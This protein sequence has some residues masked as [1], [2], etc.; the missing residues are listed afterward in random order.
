MRVRITPR[1]L[2][3]LAAQFAPLPSEPQVFWIMLVGPDLEEDV[4]A[5]LMEAIEAAVWDELAPLAM[6]GEI[7][8][9]I[10]VFDREH[11]RVEAVGRWWDLRLDIKSAHPA[12][13]IV[14][15]GM[16]PWLRRMLGEVEGDDAG[17]NVR[18]LVE[19]PCEEKT[20]RSSWRRRR[21][22]AWLD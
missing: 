5:A 6:R 4:H 2:D 18:R 19:E 3:R 14:G 1:R 12:A 13:A 15:R 16:R 17:G 22:M 7:L 9:S 20:G 8:A 11:A 21:S 10:D